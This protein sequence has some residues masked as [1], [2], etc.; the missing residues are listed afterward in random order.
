[1]IEMPTSVT[2]LQQLDPLEIHSGVAFGEWRGPCRPTIVDVEE[3]PRDVLDQLLVEALSSPPCHVMFSGGR[4]SSVILALAVDAA[5]RHGLP[6]PI[7]ITTRFAAF[8][9]AWE[10]DWQERTV[11][12]LELS[13]WRILEVTTEYDTLGP[14][15]TDTIRRFGVYWP[16]S[17]HNIRHTA[18]AAGGGT[19]LTGGGGDELFT[20]WPMRRVPVRQLLR[21]RPRRRIPR[22][23][24]THQL[25]A[26]QRRRRLLSGMR[27]TIASGWLREPARAELQARYDALQIPLES[28]KESLRWTMATRYQQLV[29]AALDTFTA[30]DGVRLIEPFYDPRVVMAVAEHGPHEGYRSRGAALE[31]LFADLLPRDVLYRSTKAVFNDVI[32]GPKAREFASGWDGTGLD[33]TL[34]DPDVLRAEW[35]KPSPNVRSISCLHQAWHAA[36][37]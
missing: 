12:H 2:P 28:W 5:R 23:I 35:A 6:L 3:R 29:R 30:A 10:N 24:L 9:G 13:D 27:G 11:R 18:Q 31:A 26:M 36:N 4:D 37:C 32:F 34:V 22:L 33:D 14:I 19:L 21:R 15:A 7:P 1:L 8:P 16:S 20:P 25:P 17:A